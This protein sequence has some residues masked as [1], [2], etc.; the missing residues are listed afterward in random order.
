[1]AIDRSGA[2]IA[3]GTISAFRIPT[4]EPESDGTA[5]WD[6]TTV[7]I[8]ELIADGHTGLGIRMPTPARLPGGRVNANSALFRYHDSLSSRLVG[9]DH[10]GR[11]FRS[12]SAGPPLLQLQRGDRDDQGPGPGRLPASSSARTRARLTGSYRASRSAEEPSTNPTHTP[13]S[14]PCHSEALAR[15]ASATQRKARIRFVGRTQNQF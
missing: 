8:V 15:Q 11:D 5:K 6:S 12:D 14:I 13:L 1:M 3:S 9:Q 10:A 2:E 4:E 7:V